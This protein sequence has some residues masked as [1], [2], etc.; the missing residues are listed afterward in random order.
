[1]EAFN[2]LTFHHLIME[3]LHVRSFEH[4]KAGNAHETDTV[5]DVFTPKRAKIIIIKEL[6]LQCSDQL[7]IL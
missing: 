4:T 5:D 7:F 1:M 6:N 3:N 2:S